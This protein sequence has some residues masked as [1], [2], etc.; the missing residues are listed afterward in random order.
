MT[1]RWKG[2]LKWVT[3]VL[4]CFLKIWEKEDEKG[5]WKKLTSF[6]LDEKLSFNYIETSCIEYTIS[7]IK[8]AWCILV[9]GGS[10]GS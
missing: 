10:Q 8:W 5:G 7:E 4:K 6:L 3:I 9:D 2:T 1:P